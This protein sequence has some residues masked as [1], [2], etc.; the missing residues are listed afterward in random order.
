MNSKYK[1]ILGSAAVLAVAACV[2][3]NV[4]FPEAAVKELSQ[5]IE[6][7]V[8]RQAGEDADSPSADEPQGSTPSAAVEEDLFSVILSLG[9]RTAYAD[10]DIPSLGITNPAIRKL[11]DS[12][13]VRL[14][15]LNDLKAKGVLGESNRALIEIRNLDGVG[16]LK[17]RAAAQRL[18]RE[19][20][21]DREQLFKEIAAAQS[22]A[23]DQLDRIR[24]TY[25]ETMRTKARPG[26]WI[27]LPN[28]T[29][30]QKSAG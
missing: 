3:I 21:A 25:A 19:E 7:E 11:I 5:Q 30:Q 24:E 22:V 9:A 28:G 27:Q 20:N 15:A 17:D 16:S 4:Y 13:A 26:D 18:V 10:D 14:T 12:R 29:W 6:D 8:E 1:W 23:L 2:T